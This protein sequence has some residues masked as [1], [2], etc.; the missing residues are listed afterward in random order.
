[1]ITFTDI[2]M[3]KTFKTIT[4]SRLIQTLFWVQKAIPTP[5]KNI[6][7][8]NIHRTLLFM[9]KTANWYRHLRKPR[10]ERSVNGAKKHKV[11]KSAVGK[12]A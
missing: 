4:D 3:V 5:Y 7:S 1:M 8:L 9:L 12:S 6:T 10:G 11:G 2:R